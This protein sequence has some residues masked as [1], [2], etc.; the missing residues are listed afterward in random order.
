VLAGDLE[1]AMYAIALSV[2][3]GFGL[4]LVITP[5]LIWLCDHNGWGRRVP[6]LHHTH[7]QPVP[8]IGGLVLAAVFVAVEA[9]IAI[10]DPAEW[11]EIP[12]RTGALICC[13]SMFAL[14]F[15]DDLKP[16]GA[17]RKLLAQICI[18]FLAWALGMGIE[19]FKVPFTDT[20]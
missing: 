13:L 7:K 14:G 6:A 17:K 9:G 11:G 8:R 16:L 1:A 10:F 3:L 4:A 18:A 5:I 12:H 19:R 2:V 20:M 15:L